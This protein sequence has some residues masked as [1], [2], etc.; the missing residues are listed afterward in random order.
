MNAILGFTELL[1]RGYGKSEE[2][3]RKHLNTISSSG[4]H[5]LDL[6]NDIL[7]LSKIESGHL[8]VEHARVNAYNVIIEVVRIL[9]VRADEKAIELESVADSELP[10]TIDCDPRLLRQIVTNLVGNAIKFTDD[11]SVRIVT[12][13]DATKEMLRI[14]VIDTGIGLARDKIEVIFNPF[15]QADGSVSRRFGGTGLG[16][17]ISRRFARALDGDVTVTSEPDVGS[18]FTICIP[19]GNLEGVPLLA[20]ADLVDEMAVAETAAEEG[21]WEF[22]PVRILVVDDGQENLELMQLVLMEVGLEIDT[23]INGRDAVDMACANDY[24]VILMDVQMP[25]MDGFTA[26]RLL[27]EKGLEVPIVALTANAMKGFE[28]ECFS[29]GYTEYLSKPVVFEDLFCMLAKLIGGQR[30]ESEPVAITGEYFS[31]QAD[32]DE[33]TP[34]IISAVDTKPV[35]SR[36]AENDKLRPIIQRFVER[37]EDEVEQMQTAIAEGDLEALAKQ[38]HWLKGS[39][40]TCG[41]DEFFDPAASLEETAKAKDLEAAARLVKRIAE[42]NQRVETPASP[43]EETVS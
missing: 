3:V 35:V 1:K 11:G 16:L 42:L 22:P 19:T 10:E 23:A 40:G 36:L 17:A 29:A 4:N 38:A 25:V 27:R 33:E 9:Q 7:D 34:A 31:Q 41:F 24:P 18:T 37:L 5:L 28:Q 30:T 2:D 21:S 39:G 6:I 13:L 15:E 20:P 14:D 32:T 12:T 43:T 8:E 26:T